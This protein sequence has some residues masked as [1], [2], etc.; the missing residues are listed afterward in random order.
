MAH[1]AREFSS[2]RAQAWYSMR[3]ANSHNTTASNW[4]FLLRFIAAFAKCR[5]ACGF[6]TINSIPSCALNSNATSSPYIPV[7][8]MH[9]LT[10]SPRG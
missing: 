1:S 9:T 7:A 6:A 3:A 8:S 4:S 5:T 10:A 2:G